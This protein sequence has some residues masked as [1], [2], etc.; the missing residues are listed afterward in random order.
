MQVR[1]ATRNRSSSTNRRP[2]S[3]PSRRWLSKLA[4]RLPW[5]HGESN[6]G[7]PHTGAGEFA[8]QLCS[9]DLRRALRRSVGY[10]RLTIDVGWPEPHELVTRLL[11]SSPLALGYLVD[12]GGK[13]LS[14]DNGLTIAM[15]TVVGEPLPMFWLLWKGVRGVEAARELPSQQADRESEGRGDDDERSGFLAQRRCGRGRP[16]CV[17]GRAQRA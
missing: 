15:F 6:T 13:L 1:D 16:Q 9:P 5:L 8:A 11:S 7:S 4:G 2:R 3:G 14:S 17:P 12:G 10:G